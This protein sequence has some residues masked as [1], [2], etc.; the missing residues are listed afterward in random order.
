MLV[1]VT[2]ADGSN[3]WLSAW[4]DKDHAIKKVTYFRKKYRAG[5]IFIEIYTNNH[6]IEHN[7]YYT[8]FIRD[9]KNAPSFKR[10]GNAINYVERKDNNQ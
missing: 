1:H 7:H 6:I 4:L 5:D 2:F 10:L 8:W 9:D 3:P